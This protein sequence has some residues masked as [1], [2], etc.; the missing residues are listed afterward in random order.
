MSS[1]ARPWPSAA[2]HSLR[3]IVF[4]FFDM[5][6]GPIGDDELHAFR[7]ICKD[8]HYALELLAGAFPGTLREMYPLL[9]SLQEKLG[10]IN[11][12]VVAREWCTGTRNAT[13]PGR[14]ERPPPKTVRGRRRVKPIARRLPSLVDA[15][16][17]AIAAEAVRQPAEAGGQRAIIPSTPSPHPVK[18]PHASSP[19][20]RRRPVTGTPGRGRHQHHLEEDR[21]RQQVPLRGRGRRRRQQGRQDGRPQR[22]V[23]VR[24]AGL[25]AA[26]DAAAQGLRGPAERNY[27]HV[28]RLLGRRHQRRRLPRPDRHRL[29]RRAV[30][31]DGEPQGQ[32][33]GTGRSTRSGTAPATRR[34][35]TS[36]CSAPA[37]AC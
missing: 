2:G 12:L 16:V 36:T 33:P 37:S 18:D 15:R 19:L 8:L 35:S 10:R 27:S 28:L 34:R 24:G 17:V 30:L 29:P 7:I 22:R 13:R 25:E 23:L 11:D 1:R 3:P 6:P 20:S 31:L 5:F 26:R 32:G 14:I 9:S 21:P 4:S